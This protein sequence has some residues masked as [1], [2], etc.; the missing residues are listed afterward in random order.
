MIDRDVEFTQSEELAWIEARA[1][2]A[3]DR[4]KRMKL[5]RDQAVGRYESLRKASIALVSF[6]AIALVMIAVYL[7]WRSM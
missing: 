1:I 4:V 6:Q 5:E 7:Y 3:V 2:Q